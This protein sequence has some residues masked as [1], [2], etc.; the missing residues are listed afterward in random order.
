MSSV[1]LTSRTIATPGARGHP[2]VVRTSFARETQNLYGSSRIFGIGR[3]YGLR[4][5][6]GGA[7][8]RLNCEI[9]Q[10]DSAVDCTLTENINVLRPG[11]NRQFIVSYFVARIFMCIV[12]MISIF[13][14]KS[15]HL[16]TNKDLV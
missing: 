2:E 5:S 9:N 1:K 8:G 4:H 13:R 15:F 14:M 12:M 10:L 6:H 3:Y 11:E 7:H 16:D